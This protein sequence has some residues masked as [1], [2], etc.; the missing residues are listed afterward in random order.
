VKSTL[1]QR[2]ISQL[3]KFEARQREQLSSF[4]EA[5]RTSGEAPDLLNQV[6]KVISQWLSL[7]KGEHEL[8]G[9]QHFLYEIGSP[10]RFAVEAEEMA[11]L[12]DRFEKL[13]V[14]S[15]RYRHLFG[16]PSVRQCENVDVVSELA[17][18]G[19]PPPIAEPELLQSWLDRAASLY[20]KYQEWYRRRHKEWRDSVSE[21]P[22]WSYRPPDVS[23]SKHIGAVDLVLEL[24]TMQ[25]KARGAICRGLSALDFQPL[26]WC[27]F[28]GKESPITKVVQ[29]FENKVKLLES[30]LALFFQQDKVKAKVKEWVNQKVEMNSQTVSY[31]EGKSSYPKVENVAIFDQHLSGMELTRSVEADSLLDFLGDGV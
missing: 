6:E 22:I 17:A 9:F 16:Y 29:E 13:L 19:E 4:A 14:E 8:Q 12:P 20:Q 5:L 3:R 23:R 25:S 26:C 21:H 24:E 1:S 2:A 28:D 27:G 10:K 15:R 11:L 30:E 18:L 7:E 31:L